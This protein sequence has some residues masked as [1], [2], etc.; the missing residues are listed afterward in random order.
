MIKFV[1][2]LNYVIFAA[3]TRSGGRVARQSSAKASTAVRIRSGPPINKDY[4]S[5]PFIFMKY[6]QQIG[7]IASLLVIAICFLPWIE[8]P[9][10]Q[11][12][13]NG[14][15]GKVNDQLSFGSQWKA[16]SFFCSI[17]IILF[18]IPKLWA[19]RTNIFFAV[20]H[21]GWAIKNYIIFSMCR[22][23]ECPDIKPALYILVLL[24][25]VIQVMALLPKLEIKETE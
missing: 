14:I 3:E 13:L 24:A 8:V 18:L 22:Q 17:M 12:T 16:H 9:S 11:L 25:L 19:K 23:G 1:H 20:M 15:H 4:D 6:S 21:L 7:I 2:Y 10:L 5:N